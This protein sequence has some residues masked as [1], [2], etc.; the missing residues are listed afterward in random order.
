MTLI[1]SFDRE[2]VDLSKR[3]VTEVEKCWLGEQKIE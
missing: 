1:C 3:E 2:S